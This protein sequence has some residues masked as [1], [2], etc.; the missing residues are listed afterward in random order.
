MFIYTD[1][2]T[3]SDYFSDN[4]STVKLEVNILVIKG[5]LKVEFILSNY[6]FKGFGIVRLKEKFIGNIEE[7]I[8][9]LKIE[10]E[11]H[12]TP[13]DFKSTDIDDADLA[14]IFS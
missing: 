6:F 8:Y 7:L 13:S 14:S 9:H 11:I 4:H 10:K 2:N 12:L 1:E 5:E 3:G